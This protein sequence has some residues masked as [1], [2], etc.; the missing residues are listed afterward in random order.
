MSYAPIPMIPGP[1]TVSPKVLDAMCRDFGSGQVEKEFLSTYARTGRKLARLMGPKNPDVVL[2]T[3]EGML[4]LWGALKSCLRPGDAVV[5]VVNGY[6]SQG[7]AEMAAGLGCKVES[8]VLP[9]DSTVDADALQKIED[10]VRRVQPVMI[11]AVHCETPSGTL[12]PLEGIGGIKKR[13]GV[14]LLYVDAVA[15][16]G[17]A[18]V[19]ADDWSIDLL[20]AGSQ[21]CLSAPPSM[22]IIGVSET[23]WDI[24]HKVGYA[25]YDS[26]L[27][28]RTVQQDGRCPYTP[29][30]HG[31]AALEAAM[32]ILL[33]EGLDDVFARHEKVAAQCHSGLAALGIGLFPQRGAVCSPTVTAA[34]VP[35]GFSF[36]E[37]QDRL[38]AQG[39]IV[40]GSF[41]PMAGKVFRLGHMGL[42]ADEGLM[43]KALEA[44]AGVLKK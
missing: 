12:N 23:A 31:V 3:G 9:F 30:W 36:A 25:G 38:R 15:S 41:G 8:V 7:I 34:F 29:Y 42:Q 16:L 37:W 5:S 19:L 13:L 14:P 43:E 32:D 27:P 35:Q 11:T 20:L 44:I 39:L 10:C 4:A 24:M 28:F 22:T 21:K 40:G 33:E 2:M 1:T 6:F 26:I 17:G 18:P